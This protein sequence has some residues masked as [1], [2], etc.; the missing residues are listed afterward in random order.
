MGVLVV[1]GGF[2]LSSQRVRAATQTTTTDFE[3]IPLKSGTQVNRAENFFDLK[4]A[5]GETET[6]KVAVKN[7]ATHSITVYTDLRNSFTQLGGGIDFKDKVPDM[8]LDVSPT[9]TS[10]SKLDKQYQKI[11]L[12]PEET[13]EVEATVTMP[14]EKQRGMIYGSWHFLEPARNA[15]KIS[16]SGATS[17]YAYTIGVELRGSQYKIYPE[18]KY[19]KVEP[20]LDN[21]LAKM[22]VNLRNTQPMILSNATAKV[23]IVKKGLFSSQHLKTVTNQKIAP[24]SVFRIPVSWDMDRLKPGKYTVDVSVQGN[25]LWNKLPMTWKFKKN[26]TI[27]SQDVK[28]INAASLKKPTNKWAYVATVAGA[29]TIVAGT[30]WVKLIKVN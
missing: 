19:E 28:K 14:K 24:N 15:G 6:L 20:I 30:A 5:P 25:N 4:V 23:K 11:E 7:V 16:G 21:G 3:V 17:D 22:T 13:K 27:K 18:L 9:L 8:N 12:G 1:A 2:G 29:L 26:F 10:V